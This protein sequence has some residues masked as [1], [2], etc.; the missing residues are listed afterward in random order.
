MAR[1]MMRLQRLQHTSVP[2]PPGEEAHTQAVLFY[3]DILGMEEIPKPRTFHGDGPPGSV[4]ID[5]SW[6]NFGDDEIHVYAI[7][8]DEP[9]PHSNAHFCLLV[10]S[11]DETRT[12]L[13]AAGVRCADAVPIPHR[14]RFYAY[15]PFGNQI[16]IAA[17]T[18]DYLEAGDGR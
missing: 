10:A 5:V 9:M 12:H 6:F 1:V 11:V 4:E 3:A 13:E 18:G 14:P 16:E 15:D 8:R 17:I 2:R 7:G